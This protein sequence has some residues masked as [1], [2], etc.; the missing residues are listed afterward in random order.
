[1]NQYTEAFKKQYNE[2]MVQLTTTIDF[3]ATSRGLKVVVL[4]E[5]MYGARREGH[6][7]TTTDIYV[8][9]VDFVNKQ[10]IAGYSNDYDDWEEEFEIS[11][12]D[13]ADTGTLQMLMDLVELM[14]DLG[15]ETKEETNVD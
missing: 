2:M 13:T 3:L 1:M 5:L 9:E 10:F 8:K 15:Y 7:D 6:Q 14:E 12:D 11:F 4:D